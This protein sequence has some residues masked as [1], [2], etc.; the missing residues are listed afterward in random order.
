MAAR[1]EVVN[2]VLL[3]GFRRGAQ[4]VGAVLEV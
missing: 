4:G 1:T 3:D 2:G